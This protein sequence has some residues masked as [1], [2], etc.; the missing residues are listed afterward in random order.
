MPQYGSNQAAVRTLQP[1]NTL[2]SGDS[3]VLPTDLVEIQHLPNGSVPGQP[4]AKQRMHVTIQELV[5]AGAFGEV[6]GELA[7]FAL[8]AGT[9]NNVTPAGWP[10]GYDRLDFNSQAGVARVTSL[11]A[12]LDGQEVTCRVQPGGNL[13]VFGNQD[14]TGG[15]AANELVG[16]DDLEIPPGGAFVAKYYGPNAT[17]GIMNGFWQMVP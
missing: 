16:V 2:L 13:V 4:V 10:L 14:G 7:Y 12:G 6:A 3:V 8:L 1:I 5:A 15:I 9:N 11:G 17:A